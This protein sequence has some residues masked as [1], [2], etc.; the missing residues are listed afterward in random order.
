MK[1][2]EFKANQEKELNEFKGIFFAFDNKQFSKGMESVG[3]TDNDTDK[4]YKLGGGSYILKERNQAFKAMFD[5]HSEEMAEAM[6]NPDFLLDALI[7]EL[8]NHEYCITW[9]STDALRTLGLKRED[10]PDSLYK[11][12]IKE[13]SIEY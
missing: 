11:E 10:I 8:C 4:I 5:R 12:A 13:A 1:Y 9:D 7:Y 2:F 6:E 3:L